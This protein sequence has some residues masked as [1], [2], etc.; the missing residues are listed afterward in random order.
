MFRSTHLRLL[1]SNT[2]GKKDIQTS[3]NTR[4][5]LVLRILKTRSE[6]NAGFHL[7]W[8][9]NVIIPE[10]HNVKIHRQRREEIQVL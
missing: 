1:T 5:I 10:H 6:L 2:N 8:L 9:Q 7:I 3:M 4:Y